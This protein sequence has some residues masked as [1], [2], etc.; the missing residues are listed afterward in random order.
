[1]IVA[2]AVIKLG[3]LYTEIRTIRSIGNEPSEAVMGGYGMFR[4]LR[5]FRADFTQMIL[6]C[7]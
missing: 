5:F 3:E 1:M 4:E 6:L 2:F 7:A